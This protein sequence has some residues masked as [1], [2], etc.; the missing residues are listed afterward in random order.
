MKIKELFVKPI[1]RAIEG[2][3][4][5]DDER[6]LQIE[7]EEYVV[8]A[9][10]AQG[11]GR[12]AECYLEET[13]A[14]GVWISGF[15]GSGKSH[16]LKILSHVLDGRRLQDGT[17]PFEYIK[18]KIDDAIICANLEKAANIP[19]RSILFNID[20]KSDA[21]GG[22]QSSPVLEVF[23][24]VLN[25]LQGYYAKQGHIAQFEYDLEMRN[26]LQHFK[27]AYRKLIG[28]TWAQDLPILETLENESFAKVYAEFFKKSYEE[29][30]KIFD[31]LRAS[32]KVSIES[33][34]ERVRVY[35]D[36]QGPTFR[37]NFFVDEAGQ[38]I[39]QDSKLMLNLQTIAETLATVCQGRS[40]VFVTS[41]GD[42]QRVLGELKKEQGQDFTKIAA[43][44]KTRLTLTGANVREVIQK[45]L[46]AKK[47]NEPEVLTDMYDSEKENLLTLYRFGD[48]GQE[49][50]GWRGSDEFC[51]YYPFHPYQFDLFQR[52][53]EQL[54]GHDAF[55]GK[56][57]SVGERSM[58]GV[59]QDVAKRLKDK[60]VGSLATFD[61]MFEG[62]ST[63]LRGDI[64]TSV[65]QADRQIDN[66][67][68]VKIIK[69]LFLLKWVKEF[70]P[71]TRNIAILLIDSTT[72]KILDH[73]KSIRE[74]L[75][76]LAGQSYLQQNGELFEFLTDK[77][78]DIENEIKNTDV[79]GSQLSKLLSEVLFSD[80]LRDP[81][82]RYEGNGQDYSYARR[83]DD[84]LIGKE[85]DFAIN[86]ITTEHANYDAPAI[87]A[88]QNT[89]KAE[90]L[91]V[92]PADGRIIAEARTFLKTQK[93]VQQSMGSN[94]DGTRRDI[95]T[96]RQQQNSQRRTNLQ[97]LC[98]ELL[99]KAPL[100][101]NGSKLSEISEGDAR[102]RFYKACQQLISF[103]YPNLKFLKVPYSEDTLTKTLQDPDDLFVQNQT[104]SEAEQEILTYVQLNQ[105]NGER[106]TIE[107]II[108]NYS[109]RPFGWYSMAVLTIIARLFRM[110]KVELRISDL[111]DSTAAL[112]A[113]RNSRQH[114]SIRVKIQE[115]FD[116]TKV[117]ALKRFHLDFF[118]QDNTGTDPRS[119]GQCT[120]TAFEK[121]EKE[122]SGFLKQKNIYPFLAKLEPAYVRIKEIADKDFSYLLH[123]CAAFKDE[124]LNLKS[125]LI[126]PVKS[127]L[128][129]PQ[130]KVYTEVLAF[131]REQEANLSEVIPQDIEPLQVLAES[132]APFRGTFI[133]DAKA[134]VSRIKQHISEKL[135]SE[136][137]AANTVLMEREVQ[138]KGT[139]DFKKLNAEQQT[140][141]L[142]SFDKVKADVANAKFVVTIKE[143]VSRY[144][145]SE[146]PA[147]LAMAA[148]MASAAP[149]AKGGTASSSGKETSVKYIPVNTI[150][151][152]SKLA[153]ITNTAELDEWVAD[154]KRALQ[155]ELTRGNR[156][157]L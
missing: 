84:Q 74:A 19:S 102:T 95:L 108:R 150:K 51:A 101:L 8:T 1:E 48:G 82:I 23:M 43:R 103:A 134:A 52:A 60:E 45:R 133:P 117:A 22:D 7:L 10:V 88:A 149:G 104:L 72:V 130:S 140:K 67:I 68:A 16:L 28:R 73:E 83:L 30:L 71:T 17:K 64:Q 14:N 57:T 93:Y 107:E 92:L 39:G 63:A 94:I 53:I 62:I 13:N 27:D 111:L 25:E 65:K 96:Q 76:Y 97:S 124:L 34:A 135:L 115:Q 114:G 41:Q 56:N 126:G 132:E 12:F 50:K 137:K 55:T 49:F 6:N 66:P 77:E 90:L 98:A 20:Q 127:F 122:L 85:A 80:V 99:G 11:L 147:Q 146:Y 156:I 54:S 33:F 144:I 142:A 26:E 91:T 155:S 4:K 35:I 38:F 123:H 141:V 139:E 70:K 105:N 15:F 86:I 120:A 2:V 78:K 75:A 36:K 61:L 89:G 152:Q 79:D 109:K 5:A 37:L 113:L 46:L 3:I 129:G 118:D 42:L 44:F 151:I 157:S 131:Y 138:L 21:I 100:Y 32:Y 128:N 31:R 106:T 125:L 24:K 110:G 59:F 9:E 116:A 58:L 121:E 153:S 143:K 136:Q 18:S 29:G 69:A 145:Q 154:Y 40:W 47:E 87:L 119:V 112:G 148:Q 81:K